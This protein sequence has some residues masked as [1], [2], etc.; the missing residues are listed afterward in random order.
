MH[1]VI[2]EILDK[3]RKSVLLEIPINATSEFLIHISP[4]IKLV[5]ENAGMINKG[6]S[7]A[8]KVMKRSDHVTE[9]SMLRFKSADSQRL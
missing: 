1:H 3:T 2:A 6:H 5:N 4:E 8:Q 9:Y 7:S